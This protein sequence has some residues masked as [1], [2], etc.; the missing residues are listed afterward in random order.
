[1]AGNDSEMLIKDFKKMIVK[2]REKELLPKRQATDMLLELARE[3][4]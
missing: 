2:L 4:Y 1:M 3:G